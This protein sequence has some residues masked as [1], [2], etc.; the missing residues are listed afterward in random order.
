MKPVTASL[1]VMV[2]SD[3]SPIFLRVVSNDDGRRWTHGV[4]GEVGGIGGAATGVTGQVTVGRGD[5]AHVDLMLLVR[6]QA[7]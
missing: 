2:T 4:D 1:K 3:V 6:T 7:L 5:Q